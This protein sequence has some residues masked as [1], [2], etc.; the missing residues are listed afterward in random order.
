[1]DPAQ[2]ARK[3]PPPTERVRDRADG[4]SR[5][6]AGRHRERAALRDRVDLG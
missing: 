3:V 4:D 6:H 5:D 2:V 1:M